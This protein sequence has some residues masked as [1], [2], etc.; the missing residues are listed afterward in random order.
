MYKYKHIF[1]HLSIGLNRG[2]CSVDVGGILA[3]REGR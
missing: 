2:F 3:E 1:R